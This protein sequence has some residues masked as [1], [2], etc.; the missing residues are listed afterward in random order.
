MVA[1]TETLFVVVLVLEVR[2]GLVV[3]LVV[4]L[5]V[6]CLELKVIVVVEVVETV[7]VA[8]ACVKVLFES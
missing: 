1:E 8:V 2:V 5:V 7:D 3:G 4:V 6:D